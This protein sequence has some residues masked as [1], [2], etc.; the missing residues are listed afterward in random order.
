[1]YQVT[2]FKNRQAI[3]S[4]TFSNLSGAINLLESNASSDSLFVDKDQMYASSGGT[5]PE[6]EIEITQVEY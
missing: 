5:I 4:S 2:F 3:K 6:I 1:M